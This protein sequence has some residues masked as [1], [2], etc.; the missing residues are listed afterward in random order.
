MNAALLPLLIA[1]P[2]GTAAF[3]VLGRFPRA[4]E[5]T[6]FLLPSGGLLAVSTVLLW[7]VRDGTVLA[8]NVALWPGG[9]A[10]PLV[11]DAF[12]A[13]MLCATAL[14]ILLC[15]V[16]AITVGDDHA[17][18]FV[19]L[20]LVMAA[21]VAGA[22]MTA[23]LFNMFVFIE[24]M[25]LPS[26]GLLTMLGS[27]RRIRAGRVYVALNLLTS[28]IFMAGVAL[29]YGSAGTVNLA[30]LAGAARESA[31][32]AVGV[33]VV[34]LALWVKAAVVP[35]HGWL[36]RTYTGT[37]VAVTA[38]FSGLHTKVAIY[39]IYR[40]YAV[41]FDGDTR[42]LWIGV[43]AFSLTMA[44][45]VL[46]A[47]GETTTR[48]ILVF[49]MISQIGYI[50]LGVAL[51]TEL[52]L[53]AGIFYL[54]HNMFV[55]ASLFLSTG[56]VEHTYG[57][58]SLDRLGGIAR[59]EPLLAMVFLVGALSLAGLPP[60]SGFIAKVT[61]VA[62]AL[63]AQQWAAAAIAVV[64]SVITLM[65]M[66]KIWSGAFW[67]TPPKDEAED[68]RDEDAGGAGTGTEGGLAV[69]APPRVRPILLLPALVL[70]LLTLALGLGGQIL[71]GLSA[72]AATHLLDPSTY[73]EA[74][75]R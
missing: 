58:D 42:F 31:A 59:R 48:S 74:V 23:D 10:I 29:V 62:A 39:A 30:S 7:R 28:T 24:V 57:T 67:G 60:F 20:V 54:V 4:L 32:V 27:R 9:V 3:L 2:L 49:H 18:Y 55:K 63:E 72:Q 43:L 16:F 12:S 22:L 1:L 15:S 41:A 21:G 35:V 70:A 8:H 65:S 26:Y 19:P 71:L 34:V 17:S 47:V 40:L 75:L 11:V 25:L 37:S 51:F 66:M 36:A 45:G 33:G 61:L 64:V 56:A 14:L 6:L 73:V 38:L 69:L 52:G 44:I 50:L 13:L 5:R 53:M 68:A 46:G